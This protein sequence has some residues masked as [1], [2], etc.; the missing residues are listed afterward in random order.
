LPYIRELS[1][2]MAT[3][4]STSALLIL[5]SSLNQLIATDSVTV[6]A[7]AKLSGKVIEFKVID[8]PIHCYILPYAQGIELQQHYESNA[9]STL[10]GS[11]KNFRELALS[12]DSSEHFFGN[13]ISISGD[14]QLAATFARILNNAKIDWQGIIASL[15]GDL[16]AAELASFFQSSKAQLN[17]TK[18]SLALNIAE[19][20]QEEAR[21][22]PSP[23]EIETFIEDIDSVRSD[24]DRLEARL[25]ILEQSVSYA[26]PK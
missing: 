15:S 9:H 20:L 18:D 1:L 25:N 23:V 3:M 22:L 2:N 5:E 6:A 24:V 14:T 19:Y 4:L 7:L 11:L 21:T 17:I 8:A 10:M 26:A 13:G 16:V 12:E